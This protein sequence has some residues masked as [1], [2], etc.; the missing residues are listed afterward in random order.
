MPLY[1]YTCQNCN[2]DFELLVRSSDVPACPSCGS[3]KLQQQVAKICVDIKY[4]AIAKSWRQ[5]AA[6]SGDLSNFSKQ[7]LQTKKS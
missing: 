3:E 5:A 6:R 4:P 7:E 2:A 1:A